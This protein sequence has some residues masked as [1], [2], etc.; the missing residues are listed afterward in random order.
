MT[1]PMAKPMI[2]EDEIKAVEEVLRSG[3]LAH[4]KAVEEFEEAFAAYIGTRYA[5]AVSSGTSALHLALLGCGFDPG[6]EV[7][8]TPFSFIATANAIVMSG[9]KPVFVDIDEKTFNIDPAKIVEKIT[10]RTRAIMPVHLYGQPCAMNEIMEIAREHNLV[11]I[12]DACQAH[13]SQYRRQKSGSFGAGCFSFYP[14]KNMTTGEGGMVTTND[15]ELVDRI[16]MLRNHGQKE[17]YHHTMLGFN[18]RMTSI[19][20]AIGLQQLSKLDEFNARRIVNAS[21]LNKGLQSLLGLVTPV[22]APDTVHVFHQY[23][24]RITDQF[25]MT[26][27]SLRERLASHGIGS[28]V[29]YPLPIHLQPYYRQMGYDESIPNA[30]KAACEVLSLPVNPWVSEKDLSEIMLFIRITQKGGR[31]A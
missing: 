6:D 24:V 5:V 1:I 20:A 8:T 18:L 31:F 26:R 10:P 11:V 2:D 16:R 22:V 25:G 15:P 29:Y 3:V 19:A 13:G 7:I 23:T 27:D 17:R 30:E 28:E 12:E 4:G 14:T 21:H 9:A